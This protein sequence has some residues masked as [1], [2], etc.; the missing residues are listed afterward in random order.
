MFLRFVCQVVRNVVCVLGMLYFKGIFYRDIKSSNVLI[1]LDLKQGFDGGFVVK[2]CDFDSVVLL[3]LL[4]IYICY[5]V[6]CGVLLIGVCV[7]IFCWIVFEVL[8]VMYGR[9]VYG[10]VC[11]CF[12]FCV[13]CFME[14]ECQFVLRL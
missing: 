6:Y 2:L 4:V 7:G 12:F 5:L 10:L 13:S 9:Y 1:D 8:Q 14:V 3:S 11:F